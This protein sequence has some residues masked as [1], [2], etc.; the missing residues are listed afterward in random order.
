MSSC[1]QKLPLEIDHE[2]PPSIDEA[3]EEAAIWNKALDQTR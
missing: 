3:A 2:H 1:T